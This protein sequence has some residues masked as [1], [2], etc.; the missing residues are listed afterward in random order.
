[1]WVLRPFLLVGGGVIFA[2]AY[3][4]CFPLYVLGLGYLRDRR[5]LYKLSGRLAQVW[6]LGAGLRWRLSYAVP[7]SKG[8]S[9]VFCA[10]HSS[11]LD[12]PSLFLTK[13][14]VVFVGKSALGRIPL[15]G[16]MYRRMHIMVDRENLRSKYQVLK[17]AARA[18]QQG[19]SLVFFPEGGIRSKVPP[20]L[21]SFQEGAFRTAIA[22]QVPIVPVTLLYNWMILPKYPRKPRYRPYRH[23]IQLQV[24]APIPTQGLRVEEAS[25]LLK[26][27][28]EQ[29][30]QPLKE[31]F[32]SLFSETNDAA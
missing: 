7:L 21:A 26:Q 1:M 4:L 12:V 17:Q 5:P 20:R 18:L 22:A 3:A 10:N 24:H 9:Y 29:V 25:K 32:P 23:R 30:E 13:L 6:L 27:V 28:R 19:M 2:L 8:Q 14:P 31:V 15:F 11:Y 16:Y